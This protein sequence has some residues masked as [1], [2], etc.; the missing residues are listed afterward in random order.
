VR[1]SNAIALAVAIATPRNLW[2]MRVSLKQLH[3]YALHPIF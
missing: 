3:G 1:D 2:F